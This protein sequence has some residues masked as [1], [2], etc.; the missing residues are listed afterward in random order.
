MPPLET[1][2]WASCALLLGEFVQ[3]Y[4]S[5]RE[6]GRLA[7]C[8]SLPWYWLVLLV[9]AAGAGGFAVAMDVQTR[10]NAMF[11]GLACPFIIRRFLEEQRSGR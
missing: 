5:M 9:V 3:L 1:F 2:G 8:W 4:L 11:V 10:I 7:K 6:A